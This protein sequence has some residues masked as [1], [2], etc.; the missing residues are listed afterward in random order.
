MATCDPKYM[1]GEDNNC[2]D[3]ATDEEVDNLIKYWEDVNAEEDNARSP[4]YTDNESD[5]RDTKW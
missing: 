1:G 4:N 3:F 2:G 5:S